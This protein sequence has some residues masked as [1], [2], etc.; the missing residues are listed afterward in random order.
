MLST[1]FTVSFKASFCNRSTLMFL[2]VSVISGS[3]VTNGEKGYS[4]WGWTGMDGHIKIGYKIHIKPM[5][6]I[7][8]RRAFDKE[9]IGT[10][11]QNKRVFKAYNINVRIDL[12]TSDHQLL[13]RILELYKDYMGLHGYNLH[14]G[15]RFHCY[16]K[17]G[18][19]WS[20]WN[21]N[22]VYSS[23]FAWNC[24]NTWPNVSRYKS[25]V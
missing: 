15:S 5:L 12:C 1:V 23:Y 11:N 13:W 16:W 22:T 6:Y 17:L 9:S 19:I 24:N 25:K 3:Q 7:D 21:P 2:Y 14:F 20:F 18:L 10:Q 8:F 4:R